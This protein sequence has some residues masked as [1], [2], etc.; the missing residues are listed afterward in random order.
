MKDQYFG[1]IN[2]YRKYA[3][4]RL[5]SCGGSVPMMV[6][7]MLTEGD[8]RSDGSRVG[9]LRDPISYAGLDPGLFWTLRELLLLGRRSVSEAKKHRLVPR[10]TY[11]ERK[12]LNRSRDEYFRDLHSSARSS[13]S[14][15]IFFDPDNGMEVKSVPKSRSGSIKYLYWDEA[16]SFFLE[17]FSILVYQHF[18]RVSRGPY[19]ERL[20]REFRSRTGAK[21]L[22]SF[23]TSTVVYLLASQKSDSRHFV[24]AVEHHRKRLGCH[25]SITNHHPR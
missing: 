8:R 18:P 6:C 1:D 7:W 4:L 21:T 24:R 13:A 11:W 22:L 14:R 15:L 3:L 20:A 17:G 23:E 10:A 25:F 19:I 16:T 12:I 2:D 5:L 9:Y